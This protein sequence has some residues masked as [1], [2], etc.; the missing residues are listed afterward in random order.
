MSIVC[1]HCHRVRSGTQR[2]TICKTC[3]EILDKATEPGNPL[4][5]AEFAGSVKIYIA[6]LDHKA[7]LAGRIP[8]EIPLFSERQLHHEFGDYPMDEVVAIFV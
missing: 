1:E 6:K 4:G 8:K 7:I 5:S 2:K 3:V